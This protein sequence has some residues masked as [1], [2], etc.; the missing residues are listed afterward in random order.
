MTRRGASGL[1]LAAMVAPRSAAAAASGLERSVWATGVTIADYDNDGFDDVF[2]TCWG[3]NLLFH[4]NGD[5]TFSD[6]TKRAELLR[7]GTHFATGCTWIDYDRDG[8]L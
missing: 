4:N 7:P 2:V 1:L 8:K 3:Q 6:V 5:G